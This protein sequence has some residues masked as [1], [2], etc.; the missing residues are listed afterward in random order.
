MKVVKWL[1][2]ALVLGLV[3][4]S[5][6]NAS[7]L[8]GEPTGTLKMIASRTAGKAGCPSLESMRRAVIDSGGRLLIDVPGAP[9]CDAMAQALTQLP[10]YEYIIRVGDA[11]KALAVFDRLKRPIDERYSFTGDTAAIAII[12]AHAPKAWSWTVQEGRTCFADYVVRGWLGLVPDSCAGKT[13]LVPLDQKW[14]VAGWPKRFMARMEAAGTRVI[15]T[16][17]DTGSG[18]KG[19]DQLDQIPQVPRDYNGYLWVDDAAL[20]GPAIRR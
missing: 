18:L 3:I 10:R 2:W 8:V 6:M 7:W 1:G 9:G 12:R 13:M 11:A 17:S 15:V 4:I 19:I 16:D 20:I 14:K 5:F